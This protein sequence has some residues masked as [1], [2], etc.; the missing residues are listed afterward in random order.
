MTGRRS[1]PDPANE[2]GPGVEP[3]PEIQSPRE[4]RIMNTV[5]TI[6]DDRYKAAAHAIRAWIEQEVSRPQAVAALAAAEEKHAL[7]ISDEPFERMG[8]LDILIRQGEAPGVIARRVPDFL[9]PPSWAVE[10]A[11]EFSYGS[12][13]VEITFWG[14]PHGEEVPVT[15]VQT[16]EIVLCPEW[17]DQAAKIGDHYSDG[18]SLSWD[19]AAAER[20]VDKSPAVARGFAIALAAAANELDAALQS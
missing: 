18:P 20:L 13:T 17:Y 4:E 7:T 1:T 3:G 16:H 8:C 9:T 14:A 5:P 6:T 19:P 10:R 12:G 2:K 11:H 15:V